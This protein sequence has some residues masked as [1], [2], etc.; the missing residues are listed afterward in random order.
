[1]ERFGNDKPDLRFG[2][3]LIDISDAGARDAIRGLRERVA[4]AGRCAASRAGL[5]RL[6]AQ[7]DRRADRVRQEAR[8]QGPGVGRASRPTGEHRSTFG[9]VPAGRACW[10]SSLQ[11]LEAEP[12]DLL[13]FVADTAE[14][15]CTRRWRGCAREFAD[16]LK[17]RD[18]SMLAFCWVIDFPLF[19]WNEDEQRWDAIHH[20]FTAPMDEDDAAAGQ[21]PRQGARRSSTTWS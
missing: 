6:L 21:R 9:Q 11:R 16:R 19:E 18:D 17:L 12:G 2:L 8:R 4:A 10:P 7:A 15:W 14:P 3:E 20:L 5:A 1:M 13:L